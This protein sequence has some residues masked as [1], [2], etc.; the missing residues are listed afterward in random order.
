ML[1]ICFIPKIPICM[2]AIRTICFF[3]DYQIKNNLKVE[4]EMPQVLAKVNIL[5]DIFL[6]SHFRFLK[7]IFIQVY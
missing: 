3:L 4:I 7:L 5:L 2:S 1:K 6:S